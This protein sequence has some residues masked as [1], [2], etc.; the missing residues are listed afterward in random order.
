MTDK[1]AV[2]LLAEVAA[3]L[4]AYGALRCT[5]A[6]EISEDSNVLLTLEVRPQ[7]VHQC[8]LATELH[9]ALQRLTDTANLRAIAARYD[10]DAAALERLLPKEA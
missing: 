3:C 5:P 10:I 1:M 2:A 7:G 9:Q 6:V 8:L 4:A